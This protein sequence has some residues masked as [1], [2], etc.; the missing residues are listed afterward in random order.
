MQASSKRSSI[1]QGEPADLFADRRE[2]LVGCRQSVLDRLEHRLNRCDGG[3]E[4]VARPGD[5]LAAGVEDVLDVRRHLV[6]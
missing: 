1:E 5:E 4:V 2:V 3:S 6:E